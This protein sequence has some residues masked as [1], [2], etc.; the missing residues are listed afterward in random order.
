[1]GQLLQKDH[2]VC[3]ESAAAFDLAILSEGIGLRDPINQSATLELN[4]ERK[5]NE[6]RLHS[7]LP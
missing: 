6:P 3:G 5:A 4:T 2:P 1:M 7:P